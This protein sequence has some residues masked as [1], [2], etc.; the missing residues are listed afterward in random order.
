ML[1]D[2]QRAHAICEEYRAA[3]GVDREHDLDDLDRGRQIGCE[4]LVLW[5]A[6]GP[7]ESWYVDQGG[8][9]GMW[10]P[11]APR[12]GGHAIDGGHFFPEEHPLETARALATFLDEAI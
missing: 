12:I 8:P 9:I 1:S 7:L 6:S 2:P 4:T 5:S 10:R 3:A 11:W